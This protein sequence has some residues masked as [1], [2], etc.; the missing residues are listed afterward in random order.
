MWGGFEV[1]IDTIVI[2][3]ITAFAI[4]STG[5]LSSGESGIELVMKAFSFVFS[6]NLANALL[7]AS[8]LTFCL[9]TQIG[10]FIYFENAIITVFGKQT[11]KYLKWFYLMPGVLFAGVADVDKLWVFADISVAVCSLPNLV[12]VLALSGA[13]FKLMKDYLDEKNKYSTAIVDR[14]KIYVFTRK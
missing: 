6:E 4:L 9:T 12:A 2:C 13:F 1:F 5:V 7:S 14:K 11:V 3:T 10:F 8:I